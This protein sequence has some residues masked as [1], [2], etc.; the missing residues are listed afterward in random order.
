MAAG[1]AAGLHHLID[2]H[3]NLLIPR[4]GSLDLQQPSI[5]DRQ[6]PTGRVTYIVP[7]KLGPV[8]PFIGEHDPILGKDDNFHG[9]FM[10]YPARHSGLSPVPTR[11]R[12]DGGS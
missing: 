10:A 12:R 3:K 4:P 6:I 2:Q 7:N 5:V 11:A 1:S 9:P 8:I